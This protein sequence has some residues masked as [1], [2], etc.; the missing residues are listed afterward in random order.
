MTFNKDFKSDVWTESYFIGSDQNLYI[1]QIDSCK[2]IIETLDNL[3][4]F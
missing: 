4:D 2:W 3:T 1:A